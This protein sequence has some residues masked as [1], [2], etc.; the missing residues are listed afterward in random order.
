MSR[1]A[2]KL[3]KRL[4]RCSM[5]RLGTRPA[6]PGAM[7]SLIQGPSAG[8]P[9][10]RPAAAGNAPPLFHTILA[11]ATAR[12]HGATRRPVRST[13]PREPPRGDGRVARA[14]PARP[15]DRAPVLTAG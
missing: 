6:L 1:S 7:V 9:G 13:A 14:P 12:R 15:L 10:F 3:P 8:D 11:H 4:V 5:R 2:V